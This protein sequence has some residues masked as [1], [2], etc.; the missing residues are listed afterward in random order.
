MKKITN[1]NNAL[2]I[3]KKFIETN[4]I[5]EKFKEVERLGQ[6]FFAG[7]NLDVQDIF[8]NFS[9]E[10]IVLYD[11]SQMKKIT[12]ILKNKNE[13][14]NKDTSKDSPFG[15]Y[16]K[17]CRALYNTLTSKNGGI[18]YELLKELNIRA[19]PYCNLNYVDAVIREVPSEEKLKPNDK[20]LRHHF[21]HYFPLSLY[22][23]F[24]ISFFN[25]IPSCYK[26][27]SSLKSDKDGEEL[28][29]N[30]YFDDFDSLAKF[31]I[32]FTPE[33]LH[34]CNVCDLESFDIDI[35][36]IDLTKLDIIE[37]HKETFELIA[38]YKYRKDI[39]S[40]II[41]KHKIYSDDLKKEIAERLKCI[42]SEIDLDL[43][44]WNNYITSDN[45]NK[46][47]LS[48]LTKDIVHMLDITTK[49]N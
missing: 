21:D 29:L 14:E 34:V 15:Q 19:C 23:F 44:L 46:R 45:I 41:C 16:K 22:P 47:P 4:T 13:W 38:R 30:P 5:K 7:I 48:K 36:N 27:N 31:S 1:Y 35:E 28:P 18:G 2:E 10:E 39:V 24:C 6:D 49:L 12:D 25:L 32:K 11:Y 17:A 37:K 40:E 42:A 33:A 3:F 20:I 8:E 43:I 9:M 26:C